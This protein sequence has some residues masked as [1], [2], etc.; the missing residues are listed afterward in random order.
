[1][2]SSQK[3]NRKAIVDALARYRE[4]HGHNKQKE[5][6]N[7]RKHLVEQMRIIEK[8]LELLRKKKMRKAISTR[9]EF[10][11]PKKRVKMNKLAKP[12]MGYSMTSN[13]LV[14]RT[15]GFS[16][17][18]NRPVKPKG[19]GRSE[20]PQKHGL[21]SSHRKPP[22]SSMTSSSRRPPTM[23]D[24]KQGTKKFLFI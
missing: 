23:T 6:E 13:R 24:S 1:M 18:S 5:G 21:S 11:T 9:C 14:K 15:E 8:N 2:S 3:S 12:A 16:M 7:K 10:E 19:F 4:S 20:V 17:T 22:T